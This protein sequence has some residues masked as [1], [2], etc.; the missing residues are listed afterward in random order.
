MSA[1]CQD[2]LSYQIRPKP[3]LTACVI[4][5]PQ[6]RKEST[7]SATVQCSV[8]YVIINNL[9]YLTCSQITRKKTYKATKK[10]QFV[11]VNLCQKRQMAEIGFQMPRFVLSGNYIRLY[12][13]VSA[14][15]KKNATVTFQW[16]RKQTQNTP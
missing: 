3:T 5:P 10:G 4:F 2:Q 11:N 6:H 16:N 15:R 13:F 12:F 14:S 7:Y 9:A 1:L 8:S